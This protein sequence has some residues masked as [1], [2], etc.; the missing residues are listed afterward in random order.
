M[1]PRIRARYLSAANCGAEGRAWTGPV[2]VEAW[3]RRD[4]ALLRS[5]DEVFISSET[6]RRQPERET[7][8]MVLAERGTEFVRPVLARATM[9]DLKAYTFPNPRDPARFEGLEEQAR[10]LYETT[11]YA[12]VGALLPNLYYT[13]WVLRGMQQFT[14]D[15][16]LD[17][18]LAD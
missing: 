2:D 13:A 15:I 8:E 7:F 17:P 18:E 3:T 10:E 16:L 11:D 14:A 5:L 12:L 1:C 9:A 6:G 4:Q